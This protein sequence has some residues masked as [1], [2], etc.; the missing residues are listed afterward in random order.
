MVSRSSPKGCDG[1]G[2]A[3]FASIREAQRSASYQNL[4]AGPDTEE[5]AHVVDLLRNERL[6]RLQLLQRLPLR[7]G[8]RVG[9]LGGLPTRAARRVLRR[10]APA[11]DLR[12]RRGR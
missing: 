4:A 12:R 9:P 2:G 6:I 7:G 1:G 3:A 11:D 8:G 5:C 10:E